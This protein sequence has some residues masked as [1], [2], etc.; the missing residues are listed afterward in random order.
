MS[1]FGL[2]Y[3]NKQ[4]TVYLE[5][6][7]KIWYQGDYDSKIKSGTISP[8]LR[9]AFYQSNSSFGNLT[10]DC[11]LFGRKMFIWSMNGC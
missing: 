11:N 8:G 2:N 4:H 10:L 7:F 6:G 9:E 3:T 1:L 5:G